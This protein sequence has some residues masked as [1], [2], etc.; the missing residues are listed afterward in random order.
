MI[1]VIDDGPGETGYEDNDGFET[2]ADEILDFSE[3]N[4]FGTP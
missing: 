3:V 1:R 4:P 2:E